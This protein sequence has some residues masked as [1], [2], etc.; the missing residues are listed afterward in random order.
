MYIVHLLYLL[1]LTYDAQFI[2]LY[3]RHVELVSHEGDV[4]YV[5]SR[6]DAKYIQY[7]TGSSA[8]T[9]VIGR[10]ARLGAVSSCVT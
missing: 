6:N 5:L 7:G 10:S 3:F 8:G 4:T 2:L 9:N 1:C